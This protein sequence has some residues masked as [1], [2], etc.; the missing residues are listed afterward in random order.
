MTKTKLK[1]RITSQ[2]KK[3]Y[4]LAEKRNRNIKLLDDVISMLSLAEQL[5]QKYHDHALV[6]KW[7]GFRECHI[8]PDWIIIY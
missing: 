1:V 6:G 4:K 7:T 2:F 3:D 5:P 8:Q